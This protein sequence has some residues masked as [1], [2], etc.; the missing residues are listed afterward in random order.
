MLK[1]VGGLE[2]ILISDYRRL[3]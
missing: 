3:D 1:Q 2:S